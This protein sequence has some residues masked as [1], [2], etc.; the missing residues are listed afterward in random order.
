MEDIDARIAENDQARSALDQQITALRAELA[1]LNG[2]A[3]LLDAEKH[4]SVSADG[5]GQDAA[6]LGAVLTGSPN[7]R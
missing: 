5:S 3:R 6:A 4:G 7:K 2:L 1:V